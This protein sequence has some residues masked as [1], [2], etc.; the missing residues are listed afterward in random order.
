MERD[1]LLVGGFNE[2]EPTLGDMVEFNR[3]SRGG[4]G[5]ANVGAILNAVRPDTVVVAPLSHVP[6]AGT[7]HPTLL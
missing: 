4:R 6:A 3:G 5:Q 2:V 1:F 7:A